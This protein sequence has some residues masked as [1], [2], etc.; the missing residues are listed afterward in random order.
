MTKVWLITGT[1]SGFGRAIA[2]AALE[3]GDRVVA[4][5]RNPEALTDLVTEHGGAKVLPVALD[6]TRSDQIA[7]AVEASLARFGGVD[8][9]VNNA[10]YGSVGA[11]EETVEAEV[12]HHF[13]VHV[14]G[15][16]NLIRA[17]LP[18]MR[19]RGSGAIVNVSSLGGFVAYPGFGA[20]CSTKFALEGFSEA[21]AEEI[22][23]FGIRV[24]IVQPGA[25]RTRLMGDAMHRSPVLE[26][27][28]QTPVAD[29][30]TFADGLD[31]AQAGDPAKVA[32]LILH[33]LDAEKAPL[34]LAIGDDA[35]G[36]IKTK[37]AAYAAELEAWEVAA[38]DTRMDDPMPVS[39][40][41]S[42]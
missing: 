16:M 18:Q 28:R 40:A 5:A 26:P 6:V 8:V 25:F 12:R 13:D 33:A 20:Y 30:R 15:P 34:R 9:L 36:G 37:L 4:T 38:R 35:V 1:S 31:G 3:R 19:A 22:A 24:L 29:T 2:E 42:R 27:Y 14:F 23:P 41:E 11:I 32:S 17:V 39:A 7:E 10:G 21:L